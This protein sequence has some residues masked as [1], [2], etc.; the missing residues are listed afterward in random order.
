MEKCNF[1]S[2]YNKEKQEEIIFENEHIFVIKPLY[3]VSEGHMLVITKI[4][5]QNIFDIDN[6]VLESAISTAKT[7]SQKNKEKYYATGINILHAS[8][9]DAQQSINHFHLHVIPRYTNDGL[10]LWIKEI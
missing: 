7:L 4:H 1:C 5:Y 8:G 9:K 10:D 6:T 3:P 2:I